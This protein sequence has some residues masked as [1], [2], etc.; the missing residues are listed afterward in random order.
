MIAENSAVFGTLLTAEAG[1]GSSGLSEFGNPAFIVTKL[2][3]QTGSATR[4]IV[5]LSSSINSLSLLQL[6]QLGVSHVRL[7]GSNTA[8]EISMGD[9]SNAILASLNDD[10]T[11]DDVIRLLSMSHRLMMDFLQ[12]IIL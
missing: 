11:V 6:S 2:L 12:V 3:E 1:D 9:V 4:D 7:L 10:A 5:D 8:V